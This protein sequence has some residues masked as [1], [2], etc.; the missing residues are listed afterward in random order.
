MG[1]TVYSIVLSDEVVRAV[2]ALAVQQ[3]FSR[4]GLINHVLAG[5]AGLSTP[6]HRLRE[7]AH[8]VRRQ[9]AG[10]SLRAD[11]SPAGA[12]T[13]HTALHYK[14]N[15]S[16]RY[17][18]EFTDGG[19]LL[20]ELRVGLRSQ[21]EDLLAYLA[22]FFTLWQHLEQKYLPSPPP[23][24]LFTLERQRFRRGLRR[25]LST[26]DSLLLGDAAAGY[27][28]RL[29]ACLRAFFTQLPDPAA[30]L[31]QTENCFRDSLKTGQISWDL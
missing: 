31:R 15:P 22:S 14:Y 6:E 29:D 10:G 13:L 20:G 23:T 25:P 21:N 19:E 24:G 8:A 4:S 2:D 16:L 3:G 7:L 30:A 17:Q 5:F 28:T 18:L 9:A 11:V 12:L 27:I 26:Q 1:K